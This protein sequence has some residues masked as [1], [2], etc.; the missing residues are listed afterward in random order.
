MGKNISNR[1]TN[2]SQQIILMKLVNIAVLLSRTETLLN[3]KQKSTVFCSG[4]KINMNEFLHKPVNSATGLF[5]IL[6]F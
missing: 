2:S 4:T 3:H 1:C 6:G 5:N